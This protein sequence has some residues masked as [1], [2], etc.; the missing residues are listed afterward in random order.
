[1]TVSEKPRKYTVTVAIPGSI[2]DLAPTL[3]LKTILAGQVRRI[4]SESVIINLYSLREP[5]HYS[6]W[7]KL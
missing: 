4:K 6:V 5:L 3:E 7:M 2:I 1:M